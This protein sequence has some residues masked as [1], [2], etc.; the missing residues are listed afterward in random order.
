MSAAPGAVE[1]MR[2]L[3]TGGTGFVGS[4]TVA[5]LVERGHDVRLFVRAPERIPPALEPLGV[6]DLAYSVG[7]VTD[8]GA[9][10]AALAGCDAVVHCASVFTLSSR[11]GDQV[12]RN[13]RRRRGGRDRHGAPA[14]PRPDR[15]RVELLRAFFRP[16]AVC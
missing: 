8:P 4:H 10:K 16:R 12:G 5:A 14:R 3:V 1:P 9:V 7:D 6:S 2:V 13:K 11:A 15:A